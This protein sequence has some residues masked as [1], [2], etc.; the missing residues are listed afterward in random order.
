MGIAFLISTWVGE[1]PLV[2]RFFDFAAELP[3]HQLD[4]S[5]WRNLNLTWVAFFAFMGVVNIYVA[6]NF[7][8]KFWATF[9][10]VGLIGLTL[11]FIIG[12]TFWMISKMDLSDK[13]EV[14]EQE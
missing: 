1:K 9:K 14:T 7:S 2:R 13:D 10:V 12:Q 5:Q 3:T 11:V 6:Y 4:R 8:E